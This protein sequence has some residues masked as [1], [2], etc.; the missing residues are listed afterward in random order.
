MD[1]LRELLSTFVDATRTQIAAVAATYNLGVAVYLLLH[2]TLGERWSF[3]GFNNNGAHL[4]TLGSFVMLV[5][6]LL[7]AHYRR[8]W[9]A[10]ALPGCI[11]FL[12]WY[13]PYFLP[14]TPPT[15]QPT[16]RVLTYN[17]GLS[18]SQ[19]GRANIP[20][21]VQ[22]IQTAGADFVALQE[23]D[24]TVGEA[25]MDLYPYNVIRR[26]LMFF[27]N[28]PIVPDSTIEITG[29]PSG[30]FRHPVALRNLV[31]VDGQQVAVYVVHLVRPRT[32][33]GFLDYDPSER[34]EATQVI[35]EA[36]EQETDPVIVLCD[37]N[38]SDRTD[39]YMAYARL[40]QDAWRIQATGLGFTAP[41]GKPAPITR[42]DYV[43][44]SD[45]LTVTDIELIN[46]T[47]SDHFP[48]RADVAFNS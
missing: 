6:T 35:I 19:A 20:G 48:L 39:D 36:L 47:S 9:V 37:C 26:K 42:V 1:T 32:Q 40:L 10:L 8:Y 45:D 22:A 33:L 41:I 24:E 34:N 30:F 13:G 23:A 29:G 5:L 21:Q 14:K 27:S 44:L 2:F 4:I 43:W 28:Y 18:L 12:F 11:A 25:V 7:T 17:V 31:D 3:I 16:L 46:T 38:M 15:V